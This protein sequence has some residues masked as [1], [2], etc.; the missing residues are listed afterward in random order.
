MLTLTRSP[1]AV[2]AP[3]TADPRRDGAAGRDQTTSPGRTAPPHH[4]TP[5]DR[6]GPRGRPG[7]L[8]PAAPQPALRRWAGLAAFTVGG[9]LLPWCVLL[10]AILPATAQAQ[11]WSLAWVGLD[12]A[13]AVAALATAAL[14]SRADARAS[15]T[16]A[17]AGTLLLIDAWFDV[18]TSAP[19]MDHA[20]ALG[21]A[22]FLEGPLAIAA[23]WLA[24]RL[25]RRA[26]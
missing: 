23:W 22:V 21:E 16:S 4:T 26:R 11:H 15:L 3:H 25:L 17:A 10:A 14:L 13:E 7:L 1:A 18:C 8:R 2:T 9:F 12:I 5:P 20:L 6:T 19:G 24:L